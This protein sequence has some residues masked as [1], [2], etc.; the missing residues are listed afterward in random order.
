MEEITLVLAVLAVTLLG[1]AWQARRLRNEPSDVALLGTIGGVL[2]AGAA[3][4]AVL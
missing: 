2:G 3:M 4:S 1:A